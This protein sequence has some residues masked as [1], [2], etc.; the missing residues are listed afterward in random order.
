MKTFDKLMGDIETVKGL[1]DKYKPVV[2]KKIKEYEPL[3]K[4]DAM[5]MKNQFEKDVLPGMK[6]FGD[7]FK[8]SFKDKGVNSKSFKKSF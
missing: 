1:V 4:N 8:D 2:K 3:I 7:S 5:K 6:K